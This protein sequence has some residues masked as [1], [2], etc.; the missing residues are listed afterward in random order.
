MVLSS[1]DVI[2]YR[3]S[4]A[5][6]D[7]GAI[8]TTAITSGE[9]NNLWP[10]VTDGERLSGG[11]KYRKVFWKNTSV[12]DEMVLP[13]LYV[14]TL[15]TNMTC[16]IGLGTNDASDAE[17]AQG[18]MLALSTSSL[19]ALVSDGTDVR[20]VTIYGVDS[21]GA[22]VAEAVTLDSA[23]EVLSTTTWDSVWAVIAEATDSVR[24]I[25]VREGSAGPVVGSIGATQLCC[26]LWV[27]GAS[28]KGAGISLPDLAPGDNYG[29]WIRLAW[30]AAAEAV[31]PN[32][33]S[34]AIEE[35]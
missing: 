27:V 1:G 12:S 7:G 5:S 10:D 3:S 23:N 2:A 15:P 25:E 30:A 20:S 6:S 18:N 34:L 29:V 13:V 24:S 26:W 33:I 22:A 35:A 21:L 16:S 4:Q 9:M 19:L 32:S 28:T 8:S 11:E 31:R 17:A 14:P